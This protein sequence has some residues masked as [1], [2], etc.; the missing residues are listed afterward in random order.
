MRKTPA[1]RTTIQQ[2]I[3]QY[4]QAAVEQAV[5]A[6]PEAYTW[7]YIANR[8]Q[9]DQAGPANLTVVP[10]TTPP[11]QPSGHDSG[12]TYDDDTASVQ[13]EQAQARQ[14]AALAQQQHDQRLAQLQAGLHPDHTFLW[15]CTRMQIQSP[16]RDKW[17]P[18]TQLIAVEGATWTILVPHD[19]A[20]SECE[21]LAQRSLPRIFAA[22]GYTGVEFNFVTELPPVAPIYAAVGN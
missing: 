8:L 1:L 19:Y 21:R 17:L 13:A 10:K 14:R 15:Q 22:R 5:L 11:A 20:R 4:G 7:T 9:R 12:A 16:V 2:A 6:C 18:A 3:Q